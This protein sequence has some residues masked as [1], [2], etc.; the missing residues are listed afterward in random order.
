MFGFW[1]SLGCWVRMLAINNPRLE[2]SPRIIYYA[3]IFILSAVIYMT[4]FSVIS[5]DARSA[6]SPRHTGLEPPGGPH[7]VEAIPGNSPSRTAE[8]GM[9]YHDAYGN[10]IQNRAGNDKPSRERLR[11]GAY[12]APKFQESGVLPN[13]VSNSPLWNFK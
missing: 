5:A 1:A 6:F 9:G 13:P 2:I 10:T 3:R 11:P 7:P 8:G 4:G 12:G